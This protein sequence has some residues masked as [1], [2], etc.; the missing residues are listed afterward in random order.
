[1]VNDKR[2]FILI[3]VFIGSIVILSFNQGFTGYSI[4]EGDEK[5]SIEIDDALAGTTIRSELSFSSNTDSLSNGKIMVTGEAA[6]W[7]SLISEDYTFVPDY[8][9]EIPIYI[10]IPEGTKEGKYEANIALLATNEEGSILEDQLISYVPVS[11]SVSQKELT[12]DFVIKNFTVYDAQYG[13]R[14]YFKT[15]IESLGNK[16]SNAKVSIS[17]YDSKGILIFEDDLTAKFFSY[18]EKEIFSLIKE[19]LEKGKYYAKIKIGEESR[20]VSFSIVDEDSLKRSGELLYLETVTKEDDLVEIKA[21][22]LNSGDNVEHVA[23]IGEIK[24]NERIV[25]EFKTEDKIVAP[26]D[27]A[28]FSYSYSEPLSGAYSLEAGVGSKNVILAEKETK[29]YSQNAISL[30]SN[31]VVIISLV[32]LLLLVSHFV[33]SRRK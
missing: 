15:V 24:N 14:P 2:L 18:E 6:S 21:Y 33:L 16:E 1:M 32:M 12:E 20:S 11:V 9:T 5:I 30:E 4:Y 27:Y 3:L 22:F 26:G 25:E 28:I 8:S 23:L 31:V 10:K 17:I 29:F 19:D 7:I 13:E